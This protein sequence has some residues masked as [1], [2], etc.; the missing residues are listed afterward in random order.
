VRVRCATRAGLLLTA[1]S[2]AVATSLSGCGGQQRLLAHDAEQ[3]RVQ[4]PALLHG[5][6]RQALLYAAAAQRLDP[7]TAGSWLL[8]S[9]DLGF[10]GVQRVLEPLDPSTVAAVRTTTAVISA[11]SY[12]LVRVWDAKSGRLQATRRLKEPIVRFAASESPDL[13]ASLDASG[14]LA[15]WNL[16]DPGNPQRSSVGRVPGRGRDPVIALAFASQSTRLL[17]LTR[18]GLLYVFDVTAGR[19]VRVLDLASA[20]GQLP[21]GAAG[22]TLALTAAEITEDPFTGQTSLLMADAEKS[23]AETDLQSLRGHTV[24]PAGQFS[25]RAVALGGGAG[26]EAIL[27]IGTDEG[28]AFW[29]PKT[30]TIDQQATG[31]SM[32]LSLE[33][34]TLTTATAE[35]IDAVQMGSEGPEGSLE[36]YAGRP[37][38]A[39]IGGPGGSVELGQDGSISLLD[40]AETGI[41]LPT[42]GEE[43][44]AL[45]QFGAEGDL[46]ETLGSG[47]D[48]EGLMTMKP[49]S[50]GTYYGSTVPNRVVRRYLPSKQWWAQ[51][52]EPDGWRITTVELGSKYV[53]AGGQ[54]PTGTASVLVWNAK[55][56][57][58][59]HRLTLTQSGLPSSSAAHTTVP[60]VVTQVAL[61]PGR[62]LLAAY[63]TLQELIVLWSTQTWQ[64]VGAIDVGP[65]ADFS[66]SPDESQL[67]AVSL[68]DEQ[69][70]LEAGNHVTRLLFASV[71]RA[72]VE[73]RVPSPGTELAG[74]MPYASGIVAIQSGGKIRTLNSAG[75]PT[76]TPPTT[77]EAE[78]PISLAWKPHSQVLAV[79]IQHEGVRLVD[80]ATRSVSEPLRPPHG[81]E[82]AEISFSPDGKLLAAGN[83]SSQTGYPQPTTPSIWELDD[84]HLEQRACRISGGAPTP[85]EWRSWTRGLR[86]VSV[87]PAAPPSKMT[88]GSGGAPL[89]DP[90]VA[91]QHGEAIEAISTK[92]AR[93]KIG[94]TEADDA[95]TQFAWSEGGALAWLDDDILHLLGPAGEHEAVC[96]CS[97]VAFQG[98]DAV[99]IS[100]TGNELVDFNSSLTRHTK[101]STTGLPAFGLAIAGV[102]G[103]QMIVAGSAYN[104]ATGPGPS[105]LYLVS[106]SGHVSEVGNPNG[107]IYTTGALSP[108][109]TEL[110]L[111]AFENGGACF[112]Q[113]H[114]AMLDLRSGR[115]SLLTMP[116]GVSMPVVRWVGWSAQGRLLAEVAPNECDGK[117]APLKYIPEARVYEARHGTLQPA[118]SAGYETQSDGA[119]A[120]TIHGP[121]PALTR[122]GTLTVTGGGGRLLAKV[123][124]V[125]SFSVRP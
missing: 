58:P 82:P 60:P 109:G 74:Y 106:A 110:A 95:S 100:S 87:C 43:S 2:I 69:S 89:R 108:S 71:E 23:V 51:S 59:L 67:L 86:Y 22:S 63:S 119:V 29:N 72:R 101:L 8:L 123:P 15:V 19:Q 1:A 42:D 27:A 114:L 62:H 118:G 26:S 121:M 16:S 53:V 84:R 28:M 83:T 88:T 56:G 112:S 54:D 79:G 41:G 78:T 6:Q 61:L 80:L 99:A 70:Q 45:A 40:P 57:R 98:D 48:A 17:A 120:A 9:T 5:D 12:G 30:R 10:E 3:L 97:S 11:D 124:D 44:T 81:A 20:R 31:P 103:K 94:S 47:E 77:L 32:G 105:S 107:E 115:V 49:G 92:G 75:D 25:G 65:I 73:R 55:T 50:P 35:G 52:G 93:A 90:Q 102:A 21:W 125:S 116:K 113:E 4:V 111:R 38:R 85:A 66:V 37:A 117:D 68:S 7:T 14:A 104:G 91:L 76:R 24:V 33:A 46:L 64:Q 39:L 122:T 13:V 36:A 18:S 96:A 34:G